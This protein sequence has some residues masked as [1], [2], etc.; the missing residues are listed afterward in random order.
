MTDQPPS[1]AVRLQRPSQTTSTPGGRGTG[2]PPV[3]R[4][5]PTSRA[6]TTDGPA[7]AI[8][9]LQQTIYKFAFLLVP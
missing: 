5:S 6:T 8:Y 4:H 3:R 7:A 1:G 9:K 2:A